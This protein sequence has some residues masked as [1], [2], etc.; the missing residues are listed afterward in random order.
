MLFEAIKMCG[1][2]TCGSIN[3]FSSPVAVYPP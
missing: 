2:V 3:C 1:H